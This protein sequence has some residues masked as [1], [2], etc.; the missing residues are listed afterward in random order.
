[1]LGNPRPE[2]LVRGPDMIMKRSVVPEAPAASRWPS[3]LPLG[4]IQLP[5]TPEREDMTSPLVLLDPGKARA[6]RIWLGH[7]ESTLFLFDS[8]L[9]PSPV[10]RVPRG[11]IY[12]DMLIAFN[13]DPHIAQ[14]RNG[15]VVSDFGKPPDLVM[16]IA[17]RSTGHIDEGSKRDRYASLGV[18]EYWRFDHTGGQLLRNPLAGDRLSGDQYQPIPIEETAPGRLR[19]Y[20]DVLKLY[21][22]WE[23]GELQ[24]YDPASGSYLLDHEA[25]AARADSATARADAAEAEVRR[26]RNLLNQSSGPG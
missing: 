17:S 18:P 22:C 11:A 3:G 10:R 20:S 5:D 1:M 16:E 2:T 21:V 13:V 8:Y 12:P 19:G 26:L 7:R 23:D 4:Y 9:V 6:L 24:W 15:Y 25:E 14:D